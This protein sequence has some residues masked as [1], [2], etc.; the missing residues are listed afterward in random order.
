M[1]II[2]AAVTGLAFAAEC[3]IKNNFQTFMDLNSIFAGMSGV[4]THY[5]G[6]LISS[7]VNSLPQIL[8]FAFPSVLYG[9]LGGKYS[10]KLDFKKRVIP[11]VVS[12]ALSVSLFAAAVFT[13]DSG[14]FKERYAAEFYFDGASETFGLVTGLRLSVKNNSLGNDAGQG[15]FVAVSND[16]ADMGG[17]VS[18]PEESET[19]TESVFVTETQTQTE[20]SSSSQTSLTSETESISSSSETT[21]SETETSASSA[22]ASQAEVTTVSTPAETTVTTT[23]PTSPTSEKTTVSHNK[24]FFS[25]VTD[26]GYNAMEIDFDAIISEYPG[27]AAAELSN[28]VKQLEPSNKNDYTGLF[29]GK[30]LIL[31]C[32][33][34]LSDAAVDKEL[35]PTLYRM[36]HNGI[37]FSDFYQPTWGGST[38]TGEYSFVFGL[39]PTKGINS[40][41]NTK[42]NNNYFTLGNQLQRLDYTSCAYHNGNY[43]YYNRNLTHKNLGYDDFQA[44][45]NGLENLMRRYADDSTM[46][47]KT[48]DLYINNDEPFSLYYMTVS[49]HCT[50]TAKNPKVKTYLDKVNERF[51][52][53]Y[54]NTTK[55]YLCYQM[56]LDHA[57][58]VM[59][60]KLEAAGIADDTVICICPDHYPYGL[61]ISSAFGNTQ[62]YVTDLYGYKY[63]TPWEKDRSTWILWSGC[64]ENEL[65]DYACEISSPTYSLDIVPTLSNLFGLEY[66]SRLLV[67]RDVFSEQEAIA[68]WNNYSWRTERGSYYAS[69]KKFY[70]NE[71]YEYDK[72]YV[73][74]INSIVRNR[75]YYS[76]QVV[77]CD[78][79][80]TIFGKDTDI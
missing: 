51:G 67:G 62:D 53:K 31:I 61:E 14:N 2:I 80:A 9:L 38:S 48:L 65:S 32:A 40:I 58:E 6:N 41:L 75:I 71:G 3:I 78:Y 36:T 25:G 23:V 50:Y 4:I 35:T 22:V 26:N 52:N 13:V 37:Y 42:T 30:N 76:G 74:R 63:K 8:T 7:I 54:K 43:D 57:L 79:F 39:V 28:Y 24:P 66:D 45:G 11:S 69:S 70:P 34:A 59:I 72:K 27:S 29:E 17:F 10:E 16:S 44:F 12:L 46:F 68:L 73:E 60:D 1:K 18:V 77:A 56:E 19:E 47:D 64:L 49:G 21:L 20:E 15:G 5:T 55:Y 33:E